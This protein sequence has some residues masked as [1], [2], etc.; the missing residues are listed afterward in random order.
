MNGQKNKNLISHGKRLAFL[1]RHDKNYPFD[2]H[3][4]LEYTVKLSYNP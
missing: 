1:L 4:W 2:E 3:G